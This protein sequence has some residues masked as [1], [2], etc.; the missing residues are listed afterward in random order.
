MPQLIDE[1]LTAAARRLSAGDPQMYNA[2]VKSSA[3]ELARVGELYPHKRKYRVSKTHNWM[4]VGFVETEGQVTGLRWQD[5][6]VCSFQCW[7][8]R[9][10]FCTTDLTGRCHD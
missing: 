4:L 8:P 5:G 3:V 1:S 6:H 7:H 9:D 10:H 2:I